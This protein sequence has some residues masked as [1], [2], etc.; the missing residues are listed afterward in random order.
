MA[1]PSA[2]QFSDMFASLRGSQNNSHPQG[3]ILKGSRLSSQNG[4]T[5]GKVYAKESE[6]L[7]TQK[8]ALDDVE[9]KKFSEECEKSRQVMAQRMEGLGQV[10]QMSDKLREHMEKAERDADEREKAGFGV[11]LNKGKKLNR[12]NKENIESLLQYS[13]EFVSQK[14]QKTSSSNAAETEAGSANDQTTSESEQENQILAGLEFKDFATVV[15]ERYQFPFIHDT[16]TN[17][18]AL[19]LAPK[20][21]LD[22]QQPAEFADCETFLLP[23][24]TEERPLPGVKALQWIHM[25]R[26]A[27]VSFLIDSCSLKDDYK[28]LCDNKN[29]NNLYGLYVLFTISKAELEPTENSALSRG[30]TF[31]KISREEY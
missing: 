7:R 25:L 19:A 14:E 22:D 30:D 10:M 8:K 5:E 23:Y 15:E 20:G 27:K 31:L 9:H 28:N 13:E 11:L 12:E 16:A 21:F 26:K 1:Q 29:T 18:E 3:H 4:S 6:A 24:C 17:S 2:S